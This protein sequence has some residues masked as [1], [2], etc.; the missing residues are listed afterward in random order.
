MPNYLILHG[1]SQSAETI[2]NKIRPLLPKNVTLF[3]PN[4]P[5]RIEQG[6]YAWFPLNKINLFEGEVILDDN[7]IHTILGH[8]LGTKLYEF[9]AVIAFSQGCLAAMI[10]LG[11][12]AI[13][14]SKLLLFS[15]IPCPKTLTGI[16]PDY[17][18]TLA[19]IGE[20][21]T[22]ILPKYVRAF[23]PGFNKDRITV[24]EHRWGHV[25]PSTSEYK[26]QYTLFLGE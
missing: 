17:V 3:V 12:G 24:V 4:A 10:L 9:D 11:Y 20:K 1:Y 14:T 23:L 8:N 6:Q 18:E 26:K 2:T 13:V 19:Y 15:P 5:M 21:E 7:D 25:I 22:F 16:V